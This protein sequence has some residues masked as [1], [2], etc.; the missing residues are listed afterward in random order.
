MAALVFTAFN[1][2]RVADLGQEETK[3]TAYTLNRR[4]KIVFI[5]TTTGFASLAGAATLAAHGATATVGSLVGFMSTQ[6]R[7]DLAVESVTVLREAD[8]FVGQT[9]LDGMNFGA[10]VFLSDTLGG[11]DDA[12]GTVSVQIGY[13]VPCVRTELGTDRL[14]RI[15]TSHIAIAVGG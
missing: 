12:A 2:L 9:A 7:T 13:V 10:P 14:L 3:T 6:E 5:N 15:S 1:I 4:G 8:V 11:A